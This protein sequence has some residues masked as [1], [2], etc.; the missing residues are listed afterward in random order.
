MK[1]NRVHIFILV[2]FAALVV[3]AG[4]A[5]VTVWQL[6]FFILYPCLS[7]VLGIV[8]V[9]VLL[10][11]QRRTR[12]ETSR[13]STWAKNGLFMV[14]VFLM[15][16][17]VYYPL[18]LGMRDLEVDRA[19]AFLENLAVDL[20]AYHRA[21]GDYPASIVTVLEDEQTVPRLLQ[22]HGEFPFVYDNRQYYFQRGESF[23]FE[24][25]LPDGFIG[26]RYSYCCGA[27]GEWAVTD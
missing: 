24:F 8:L 12:V 18:A 7:S 26:F 25:Y 9:L 19:Q 23:A 27:D 13:W 2:V 14:G 10:A 17:I 22:L 4:W 5:Y 1:V 15:V 3:A 11:W 20:E 6:A 16:Q 21:N